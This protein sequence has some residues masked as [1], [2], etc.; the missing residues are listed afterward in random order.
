M[1]GL[2]SV[3]T[4]PSAFLPMDTSKQT[5][6]YSHELEKIAHSL[7]LMAVYQRDISQQCTWIKDQLREIDLTL[8]AIVAYND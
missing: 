1:L 6:V 4:A 7:A 3:S 5:G 8:Q 2:I